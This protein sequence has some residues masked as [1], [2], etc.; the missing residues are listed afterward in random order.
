M[1]VGG[2]KIGKGH[3]QIIAGPCS[4][5][6]ES[7]ILEAAKAIKASAAPLLHGGAFKP[8]TS[9]YDFQGL[10]GEGIRLLLKAKKTAGCP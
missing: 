8:R 4:V 7:Q 2:V 1:D 6:S 5:E 3:F 9:P 10:H